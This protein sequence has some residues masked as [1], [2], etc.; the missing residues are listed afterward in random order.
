MKEVTLAATVRES[1]GK[2]P[3]RRQ[4]MN[5]N[6]PAVVYGPEVEPIPISID[7]R[8]FRTSM[9][10]AGSST[11]INLD[12][13]EKTNKV[14]MREIQ[15]DPVSLDILHVDFYA[16]SMTR[17]LKVSIP[18]K[19]EGSPEGVRVDGGIMQITMRELDISCL[20]V[21]IPDEL[22]LDVTEL[23]IGSSIHVRDITLDKVE[24]LSPT[25][26]TVVVI[27]APTVI[28][29]TV[30]A[31]DEEA[32]DLEGVEGEEGEAAEGE[33]PAEGAEAKKEGD[34]KKK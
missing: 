32:E 21:D 19:F 20:P 5:G 27:A 29:E 16:I 9:K 11:I 18:I 31:E 34:D 23:G 25:R 13:G 28:K 6:I 26:R 10:S 2:G 14:I 24:I 1:G 4:R 12:M 30:T 7:Q 15:R 3:A 8:T 33:A 17:P 22:V